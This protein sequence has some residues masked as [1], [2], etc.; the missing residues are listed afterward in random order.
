MKW[1]NRDSNVVEHANTLRF[2]RLD[3]I[4]TPPRLF[5]LFFDEALFD[6]IV[7]YT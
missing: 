5:E 4:E 2:S 3:N 6:M 7:C 1:R